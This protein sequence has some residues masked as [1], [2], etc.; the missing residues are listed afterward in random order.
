MFEGVRDYKRF[1]NHCSILCN[2]SCF[3]WTPGRVAA[4]FA[5]ANGDP[6]NIPNCPLPQNLRH[7]WHC[8]V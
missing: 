8:V 2:V 6:N 4:A 5:T 3:G 1:G 7:L